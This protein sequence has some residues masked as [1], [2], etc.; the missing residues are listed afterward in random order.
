ML[1]EILKAQEHAVPSRQKMRENR[2]LNGTQE[3]KEF[4]TRGRRDGNLTGLQGCHEV[5]Q[6]KK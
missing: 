3:K 6:G 1:Q 5:V 2:V 4:M